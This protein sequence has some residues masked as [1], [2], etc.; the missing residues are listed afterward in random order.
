MIKPSIVELL[1]KVD[2]KYSLVYVASVRA[3]ELINGEMPLVDK[4]ELNVV[5]TAVDEIMEDKITYHYKNS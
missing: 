3:R 5:S 4:K 1:G 2:N